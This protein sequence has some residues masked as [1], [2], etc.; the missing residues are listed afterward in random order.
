VDLQSFDEPWPLFSF[1]IIFTDCRTPWTE[2]QPVARSLPTHRPTQ[3]QTFMPLSGIRTHDPSVRASQDS[4]CLRPRGHC[5]RRINDIHVHVWKH[6][7]AY[8]SNVTAQGAANYIKPL[9]KIK[10]TFSQSVSQSVCLSVL[11]SNPICVSWADISF[12]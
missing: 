6:T 7:I 5:D 1:I 12:C 9:V 8:R 3:T 2:D 11:V 10:V 4:S